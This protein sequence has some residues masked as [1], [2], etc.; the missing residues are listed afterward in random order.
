MSEIERGLEAF[1][2]RVLVEYPP[3]RRPMFI[4]RLNC[5]AELGIEWR[6]LREWATAPD[7]EPPVVRRGKTILIEREPLLQWLRGLAEARAET[8]SEADEPRDEADLVLDELCGA[9]V[10]RLAG[11]GR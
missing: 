3:A 11:G 5:R 6:T 9:G 8:E 2:R 1:I 4:S 10:V 7:F